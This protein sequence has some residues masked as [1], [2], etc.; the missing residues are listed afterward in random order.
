[1]RLLGP[2]FPA[3]DVRQRTPGLTFIITTLIYTSIVG[4]ILYRSDV[5]E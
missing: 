3:R 4:K 5:L 2:C 1:M